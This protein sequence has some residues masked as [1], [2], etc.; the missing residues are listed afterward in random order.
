MTVP[1]GGQVVTVMAGEACAGPLL[2]GWK[3]IKRSGLSDSEET[4]QHGRTSRLCG[5]PAFLPCR[6][7]AGSAHR[8][9]TI[10]RHRASLCPGP[11]SAGR[12]VPPGGSL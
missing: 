5:G 8:A 4:T 10:L 1:P 12:P 9:P 3:G 11:P 7:L 2:W 6:T